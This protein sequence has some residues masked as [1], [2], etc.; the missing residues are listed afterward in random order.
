MK[1]ITLP[2]GWFIELDD[3]TRDEGFQGFVN[4]PK[5]THTASMV[6]ARNEGTV[7]DSNGEDLRIP[8]NVLKELHK[9]IYDQY[10]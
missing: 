1:K 8:D 9:D 4:N 3:S 6:A 2:N 5:G 10:E 7:T